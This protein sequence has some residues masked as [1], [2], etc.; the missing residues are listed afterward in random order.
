LHPDRSGL[1]SGPFQEVQE[2]YGI[3]ADPDRRRRY[4]ERTHSA[5]TRRQPWG[6]APD[7]IVRRRRAEPFRESSR[8]LEE[9]SLAESFESYFPSVDEL[10]ERLWSNF[11]N[12]SVRNPNTWRV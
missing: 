9:V 3:L 4:D 2:A 11:E 7:R 8:A 1:E 10:F 6:P 12:V 5:P